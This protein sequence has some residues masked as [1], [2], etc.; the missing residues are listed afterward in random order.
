VCLTYRND[1]YVRNSR[2]GAFIRS[3]GTTSATAQS[4]GPDAREIGID[5]DFAHDEP[6]PIFFVPGRGSATGARPY[7]KVVQES[8]GHSQI[9]LAL[10]TYSHVLPHV[11]TEAALQM[12]AALRA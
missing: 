5:R 11:S 10:D 1:S 2:L 6:A 3:Q 9:S 12:D 4:P 7:P 8:L